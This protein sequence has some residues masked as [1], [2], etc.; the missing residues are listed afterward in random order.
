MIS[1]QQ[2]RIAIASFNGKTSC[3]RE[4]KQQNKSDM[5]T[6]NIL[7]LL[8]VMTAAIGGTYASINKVYLSHKQQNKLVHMSEGNINAKGYKLCQWNCGSAY[9]ENKMTEVEAAVARIK[10][11]V[12]CISESNLRFSVDQEKV[13]IPGYRLF[14]SK[15]M[16]NPALNIS[17]VVVYLD[18]NVTGSLRED[19]MDPSFSSIWIELGSGKQSILLGC[20]YREHQFM[21][22]A[23][24]S[25]LS[26]VEQIRRWKI[27]V[28]QWKTAL[29]TGVEVHTLGDFNIDSKSFGD[30]IGNQGD[31]IKCVREDII[32]QGVTQCIKSPT[33]W[34]QGLQAGVP[35]TIDHHWSTAPEKLSEF[36]IYHM[37][38]S[39]H[40]LIAVVRHTRCQKNSQQYVT[41]R[42]FKNFNSNKFLDE[43]A[44]I[45]WWEVYNCGTVDEAVR[46]FTEGVNR[47]LDRKDMAPVRTFQQRQKY[48]P[49]LSAETKSMMAERDSAVKEARHTSRPEDLAKATS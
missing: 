4:S 33:R 2:Y 36:S 12:L 27:F 46:M 28:Q 9:L 34:P 18:K 16:R 43:V 7:L 49:W 35:T 48:A 40:A 31:M 21:N 11:T 45:N 37:G 6:V 38:S 29:N 23:D 14:T 44:A 41:K 39:D 22:Q 1:I 10:P 30:T 3:N 15:T 13:Q 32:S 42:S 5:K 8:L 24:N 17:R 26:N 25:S 47:I 20:L 19:L